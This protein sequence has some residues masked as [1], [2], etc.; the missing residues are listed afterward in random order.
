MK[1]L[2]SVDDDIIPYSCKEDIITFH[3]PHTSYVSYVQNNL[4]S[5][6]I[7]QIRDGR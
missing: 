4:L 5:K 3:P 6:S 1:G 7:I 2:E